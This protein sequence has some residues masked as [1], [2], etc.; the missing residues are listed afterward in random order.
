M[1][2]LVLVLVLVLCAGAHALPAGLERVQVARTMVN[3][4]LCVQPTFGCAVL[5]V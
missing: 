2:V 1:L 5:E 4:R 3:G